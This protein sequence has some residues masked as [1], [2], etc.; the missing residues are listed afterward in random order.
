M[1]AASGAVCL[2]PGT[3]QQCAPFPPRTPASA[4]PRS[5]APRLGAHGCCTRLPARA[6][7][8]AVA[9]VA[10]ARAGGAGRGDAV[11]AHATGPPCVRDAQA[12]VW[13]RPVG[14]AA[15]SRGNW[16]RL[17]SSSRARSLARFPHCQA[18]GVL[19]RPELELSTARAPGRAGAVRRAHHGPN[20]SICS[21][22][23]VVGR[24]SSRAAHQGRAGV[25]R[26]FW[27]G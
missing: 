20:W 6:P 19:H 10:T 5:S 16:E 24:R 14:M 1:L 21:P 18:P 9:R 22:I 25:S 11:L 3:P 13:G 27:E 2:A 12:R 23:P 4:G 8:R 26:S 15:R 17:A 7:G